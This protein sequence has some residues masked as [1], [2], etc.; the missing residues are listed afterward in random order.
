MGPHENVFIDDTATVNEIGF[1]LEDSPNNLIYHN[2]I[3]DNT[4]GAFNSTP[5]DNDWYSPDLLE[6]NYWS[7]YLGVDDGSGIGKHAVTGDGIGDTDLLHPG[8][9]FD[10]YHFV[11][12]DGWR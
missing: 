7:D 1:W 2:N 6:G 3:I 9:D 10:D 4:A 12:K 11:D 8:L 5:A